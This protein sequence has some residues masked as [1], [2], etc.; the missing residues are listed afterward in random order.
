MKYLAEYVYGGMDGIVTTFAVVAGTIGLQLP[1]KTIITLAV[2]NV[3]ADGFGCASS[4]YMGARTEQDQGILSGN[5]SPL[6]ASIATFTSFVIMGLI[7]AIVFIY[8]YY[9][10]TALGKFPYEMT[11]IATAIALYSVG[12]AKGKILKKDPALSGLETFLVGGISG[13]LAYNIG[14]FSNATK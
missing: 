7:P 1:L 12:Y 13:I 11:I 4:R 2:A 8:C 6:G 10:S 5:K 9:T 3:V 14:K